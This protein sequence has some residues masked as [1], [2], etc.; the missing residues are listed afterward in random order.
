MIRSILF[1]LL[2]LLFTSISN[3]QSDSISN[4][5]K[6][7]IVRAFE[8]SPTSP[9]TFYA[10]LKGNN[11]GT[12]LIY[13]SIDSGQSW[14][15]LNNGKALDPYVSDVQSVAELNT[16]DH[17]L[18]A[19]TWKNGKRCQFSFFRYSFYKSW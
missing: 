16:P 14:F 8:Q 7:E 17:T 2:T 18:F 11:F 1:L 3:A 4:G 10:G 19:G 13:K 12:G 5:L 6:G 9:T 15:P